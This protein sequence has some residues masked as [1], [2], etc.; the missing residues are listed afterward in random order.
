MN[1]E[2]TNDI[3]KL[4]QPW[5]VDVCH[6][7]HQTIIQAVPE[8]EGF[9]CSSTHQYEYKLNGKYICL[10]YAAK[11]WVNITIFNTASLEAP[12]GFEKPV[13]NNHSIVARIKQR[14][15]FDYDLCASI[16][17]QAVQTLSRRE[18]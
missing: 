12:A 17:R 14:R 13:H 18:G 16:L 3:E 10:F 15:D 8:A 4:D 7:L 11:A 2:I 1:Q 9:K 5:K 6:R